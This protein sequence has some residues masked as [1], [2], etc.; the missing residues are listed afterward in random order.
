M[1]RA[2]A[3]SAFVTACAAALVAVPTVAALGTT[4]CL[5][6]PGKGQVVVSMSVGASS[7]E[8]AT[9]SQG[10]NGLILIDGVGC[11]DAANTTSATT[12]N[13]TVIRVNGQG[14]LPETLTID[15]A[16]GDLSPVSILVNLAGGSVDFMRIL[17][18][19][20]VLNTITPW[21]LNQNTGLSIVDVEDL[22][23]IGGPGA[24]TIDLR[25]WDQDADIDGGGNADVIYPGS[26]VDHVLGGEGRDSVSYEGRTQD[27]T[28]S[29][30]GF[31]NDG[32]SGEGD[33]IASDVERLVGGGGD[34]VLVANAWI[35]APSLHGAGGDD[36]F[37][38]GAGGMLDAAIFGG[39][40]FDTVDCS[41]M[42]FDLPLWILLD[43]QANDGFGDQGE[44]DI[45]GDVEHVIGGPGDDR[46]TG[47]AIGNVLEGG[48]GNDRLA[49]GQYLELSGGDEFL[50]GSG[51]DTVDYWL[52]KEAGT[53]QAPVTVTLDALADDGAAG[54]DFVHQDVENVRGGE[55][56]DLLVGGPGKNVLRGESG[57]D[58][59]RGGPGNDT[60]DGG[61]GADV[62]N[63]EDGALDTVTYEDRVGDVTVTLRGGA[64][65][66]EAG[67]GDFVTDSVERLIGGEGDDEFRSASRGP[68]AGILADNSFVGNGGSDTLLGGGGEDVLNG[69]AGIDTLKGGDAHDLLIGGDQD[70]TLL[71]EAHGDTLRGNRGTDTMK[72][73]AGNDVFQAVD[74]PPREDRVR[75]GP[76]SDTAYVDE[77]DDVSG[78][79][80]V[81]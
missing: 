78:C 22:T 66:G 63:G 42:N 46:I 23:V 2:A 15:L 59:L 17:G 61:S 65:D 24:D 71:G 37:P 4:T 53:V 6:E 14:G 8:E 44:G 28:L 10:G 55:G 68:G 35:A 57:N 45:R 49:G 47:S 33:L 64:D 60:L 39:T 16:G 75:G 3:A 1:R 7:G 56:D 13:T 80:T 69:G 38:L 72:G 31:A 51:I 74:D 52:D 27:L 32:A 9:L 43:G 34:D 73:N 40:G 48:P 5:Y 18:R 77:E 76:G 11:R 21:R 19:D 54:E 50:G 26:G 81:T 62:L 25:G 67:E 79:E 12:K 70:D 20:D 30:D 29:L 36:E 41:E 58:V